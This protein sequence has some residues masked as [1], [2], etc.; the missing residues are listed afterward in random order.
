MDLLEKGL[1]TLVRHIALLGEAVHGVRQRYPFHNDTRVVLPDHLHGIW[2]LPEGDADFS[3]RWRLVKAAFDVSPACGPRH[4][5]AGLGGW[6]GIRKWK[7]VTCARV[8]V[9]V[10]KLTS[11]YQAAKN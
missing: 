4:L 10:R 7:R 5:S 8:N 9:G 6:A 2:T 3:M 11:P 1:D